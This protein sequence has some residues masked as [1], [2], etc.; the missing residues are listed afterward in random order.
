MKKLLILLLINTS[1]LIAVPASA[2][3]KSVTLSVPGMNCAVCPMT[4]KK[5]LKKVRGVKSAAVDFDS[6]QAVVTFDDEKT[7]VEALTRATA[8][9][10]YPSAPAR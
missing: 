6:K 5:A 1:V 4:V 8:A 10:G 2:A 7:S 3:S 9:A